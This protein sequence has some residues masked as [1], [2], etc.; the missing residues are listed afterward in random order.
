[1][2]PTSAPR[3]AARTADG[4]LFHK[5]QS[6]ESNGD[7]DTDDAGEGAL[8]H[9]MVLGVL[10][11][12]LIVL[13]CTGIVAVIIAGPWSLAYV[14]LYI[15]ATIPGWPLGRALFGRAHP[16]GWIS[17]ALIGYG[18]TCL[19]FWAVLALRL[20]I[21]CG[22]RSRLGRHCRSDMESRSRSRAAASA[23]GMGPGGNASVD[24]SA[25]ARARRL[26][27]SV[28]EPRR[29]GCVRQSVLSRVF[30]RRFHLAYGADG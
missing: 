20:L 12:G 3:A 14:A 6:R 19:A 5:Q 13:I 29:A 16:A 26:P 17:G 30:H 4:S 8:P 1:M 15:L 2:K 25:V 23:A 22:L 7:Q 21:A 10:A 28:Q 9:G 24:S 18:L 11:A 27:L